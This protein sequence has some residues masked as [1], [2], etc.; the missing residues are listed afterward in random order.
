MPNSFSGVAVDWFAA[1]DRQDI[2]DDVV[3]A[4]KLRLLDTL[5][6]IIATSTLPIGRAVTDGALSLGPGNG[7]HVL[8]SGASAS[9]LL[10]ALANGAMGEGVLFDD[11][12]GESET[13]VSSPL[14]ATALAIAEVTG[15]SGNEVFTAFVGA[16]EIACRLG[17]V[18]PGQL[19]KHGFH[20]TGIV[21]A[22]SST[23]LA[24][25]LLGLEPR[26]LVSALGIA[27]SF[28]SGINASWSDGSW[29]QL[30]H[31]GWAAHSGVAASHLAKSGYTG[32]SRVLE[33]RFG[34]FRSHIQDPEVPFDF[35]RMAGGFGERWESRNISLK[36]YPCAAVIHPYLD[37]L[38]ALRAEYRI[39]PANV[40]RIVCPIAD[41]IVPL[42]CAP[43][44]ERYEP[45]TETQAR[46]SLQFSLAEALH[47]GALGFTAFGEATL[48]DPAIRSLSRRVEYVVDPQAPSSKRFKGHVII[49]LRDGSMLERVQEFHRGSLE[50]PMSEADVLGKFRD[51]AAVRL[52]STQIAQ[53]ESSIADIDR[54]ESVEGLVQVCVER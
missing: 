34:L 13:H 51:N 9:P 35:E 23:C 2:P 36:P 48:R 44:E 6:I 22:L 19:H 41:Y 32:P 47:V 45:A 52:N 42:V 39:Q 27:G 28:A 30:M 3:A 12:H 17:V 8:G 24:G 16:S 4:T 49:H 21:G 46:T 7:S 37:A 5:G 29:T 18:A 43:E 14:L 25:R 15:S 53:I 33:D 26:A 1:L 11:T 38:L 40:D 10:A 54:L 20:T 31:A 50:N